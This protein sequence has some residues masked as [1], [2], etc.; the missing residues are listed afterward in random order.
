MT[1]QDKTFSDLEKQVMFHKATESPFS[2]KYE[3][4]FLEGVY[5][6][7]NCQHL[8]YY[9]EDKFNAHCGW[10]AFD[11]EAFESVKKVPDSDG[12]RVEILCNNCGIHLGHVFTGENYTAKNLRHCVNSVSLDFIPKENLNS[13]VVG[14]GC[15]WGVQYWFKKLGGII[16]TE[17]GYS[18]GETE[19]PS[20]EEVCS[21][22]TGHFEVLRIIFDKTKINLEKVL[23]YFFEIHDFEQTDGQ[24]NDIGE[25][26]ES[27]IFYKNEE[28]KAI[29]K[30][31][32]QDLE[33]KNYK[34]ATKLLESKKFYLAED[35]H[36]NYYQKTGKTPYCHFYTKLF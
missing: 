34:V 27:V 18:G 25:Q 29:A 3:N 36:Q 35:Y 30:N 16:F 15:F 33:N 8:L 4:H 10:P 1:S 19:N 31:I 6:C 5:V 21:H 20:Y 13:I 9:S 26:Y 24:G 12:L 17:V 32:I 23:K 7:K 28:E 11:D 14:C 22:K 2:G